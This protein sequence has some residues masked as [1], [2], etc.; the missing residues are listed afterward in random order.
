MSTFPF[1]TVL[2]NCN[3]ETDPVLH[4][5][6][7]VEAKL[8]TQSKVNA[9]KYYDSSVDLL[10]IICIAKVSSSTIYRIQ[11]IDMQGNLS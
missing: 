3:P 1:S 7:C 4:R 11:I 8:K 9:R 5:N 6:K 2:T 10:A